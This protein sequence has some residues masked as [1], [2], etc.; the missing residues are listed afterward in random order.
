MYEVLDGHYGDRDALIASALPPLAWSVY[1]LIKTRRLDAI[2]LIVLGSILITVVA[3]ACGG[4][5]RIIQIRD[6]LVVGAIGVAFLASL[7]AR[8]P[9]VFYLAR[10]AMARNA[11]GAAAYETIW[12]RPGVPA[13]FR[14]ITIVWGLGLVGQTAVMCYLAWIWPIS[15]YLLVSPAISAGI[16]G[17]LMALSLAYI[18]RCPAARAILAGPPPGSR[19][20]R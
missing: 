11:A 2:S 8:R 4:S 16:F 18:A 12:Q 14:W 9:L 1:E 5:A 7:P 10:A 19:I 20:W 17:A 13:A 3:T 6:A 15:R